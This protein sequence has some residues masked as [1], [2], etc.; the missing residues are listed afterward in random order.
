LNLYEKLVADPN[1]DSKNIFLTTSSAG[2]A[3]V[4]E[5]LVA[6]PDIWGGV[7]LDNPGAT[8]ID[9]R[10]EPG[11]LPPMLMV[12]G[13]LDRGFDSMNAFVTWSKTNKVDIR[14]LIHINGEHGTYNLTERKATFQAMADFF[15]DHL[16]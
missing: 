9:S 14:S 12:M 4:S 13:G 2:I 6:R 11:K 3:V 5:L 10:F 15:I 8:P 7:V 1:I 16:R